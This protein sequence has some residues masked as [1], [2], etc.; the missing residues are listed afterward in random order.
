MELDGTYAFEAPP[1]AV[2]DLLM[3]TD[4]IAACIPGCDGLE[5][6]GDDRFRATLTVA[7]AAVTGT[8]QGTVHMT[9]KKPP[10]S[11]RLIVEGQGRPG[12]V[13]GESFIALSPANGGTTVRVTGTVDVGGAIARV[14]QRLV[15]SVGKMMLDRF[16]GCLRSKTAGRA[17]QE[18]G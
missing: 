5:P 8:Y 1:S 4:A 14:G 2:W 6:L 3:D 13:K 11:Y 17:P 7:L 16:F 9:D 10:E 18:S 12:F 15:A